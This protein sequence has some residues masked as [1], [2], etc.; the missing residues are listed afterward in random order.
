MNDWQR[1]RISPN[2]SITMAV[3]IG[4]AGLV[5][6]VITT[7]VIA[8]AI[9]GATADWPAPATLADALVVW[10][11]D[12][13]H[14]I[15]AAIGFFI[16]GE[17]VVHTIVHDRDQIH[18][19]EN[20]R[21]QAQLQREEEE[22]R[23]MRIENDL[24]ELRI[25]AL[26]NKP[27]EQH[28]LL[29]NSRQTSNWT[30]AVTRGQDKHEL[31][32]RLIEAYARGLRAGAGDMRDYLRRVEHRSFR[33]VDYTLLRTLMQEGGVVTSQGVDDARLTA[34]LNLWRSTQVAQVKDLAKIRIDGELS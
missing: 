15:F 34:L 27:P 17:R 24:A 28:E 3:M 32:G 29:I 25:A 16:T 12:R 22:T 7:V 33:N 9:D 20:A 30:L 31:D 19:Q 5:I 4:I 18:Y 13:L 11:V 14:L 1:E 23:R 8:R 2:D 10:F 6:T 21:M 26:L